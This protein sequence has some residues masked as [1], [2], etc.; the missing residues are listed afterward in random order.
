MYVNI[1]G[2]SSTRTEAEIFG[3]GDVFMKPGLF[4]SEIQDLFRVWIQFS[5]N[6]FQISAN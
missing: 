3:I 4:D 1:L 6:D 5:A 2:H